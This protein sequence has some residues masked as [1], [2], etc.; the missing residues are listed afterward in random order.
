MLFRRWGKINNNNNKKRDIASNDIT[1][2]PPSM[3]IARHHSSNYIT[4]NGKIQEEDDNNEEDDGD[5]KTW[6]CYTR[7]I[8]CRIL[9]NPCPIIY[10]LGCVTDRQDGAPCSSGETVKE[11]RP[12][13]RGG[14]WLMAQETGHTRSGHLFCPSFYA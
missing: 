5:G 10:H 14:G 7:Y 12:R 9:Y 6:I 2:F 1:F 11:V 8:K 3:S 13:G 4:N